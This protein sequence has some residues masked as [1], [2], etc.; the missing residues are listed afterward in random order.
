MGREEP[1][2]EFPN[3]VLVVP[4][5]GREDVFTTV[6]FLRQQVYADKLS[7]VIVD[8]GNGVE[9]SEKLA[10]LAGKDCEVVRLDRNTGGSGAFRAGMTK[11][12]E[13]SECG[14][15]WLLDDDALVNERTLPALIEEWDLLVAEGRNPG[16]IGSAMLGRMMPDRIIEVGSAI[17]RLTSKQCPRFHGLTLTEVGLR[18]DRVEYVAAASLLTS[19]E[20]LRSVGIFEDVFIHFDDIE[21]C[22][23]VAAAGYGVYA[24]TKSSVNHMESGAKVSD[25]IFYYNYR[26]RL[27]FL[28]RHLPILHNLVFCEMLAA[29]CLFC[30]MGRWAKSRMI[31]IGMRH[32]L[33]GELL[34]RDELPS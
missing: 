23:R 3:V 16:A 27:W 1:M 6:T 8:N 32:S 4:V 13:K 9:L 26:N 5:Y 19:A 2:R 28:K 21:W 20:V 11:A 12:M 14:N 17:S 24:T 7:F 10:G 29:L 18:T 33:S 15:I 30:L 34:M 31:W 25:W 22:F